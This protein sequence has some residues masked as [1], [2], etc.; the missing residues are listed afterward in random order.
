M[1]ISLKI[2]LSDD[3][4][5]SLMQN[6][7]DEIFK[8]PETQEQLR[9]VILENFTKY[10]SG[11][12]DKDSNNYVATSYRGVCNFVEKALLKE[13]P[14][15]T[16][17]FSYNTSTQYEPTDFMR[18]LISEATEDQRK[19]FEKQIQII[20][21]ELMNNSILVSEILKEVLLNSIINGITLGTSMMI[22]EK[23]LEKQ[24]QD[25]IYSAVRNM[26]NSSN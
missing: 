19:E 11:T 25:I 2:E 13:V 6:S 16:S 20:V 5:N 26:M 10:F 7:Y 4:Y 15:D 21:K 3:Q 1:E 14:K 22:D 24:N 9:Q 8:D 18:Q 12:R 23:R 17:R